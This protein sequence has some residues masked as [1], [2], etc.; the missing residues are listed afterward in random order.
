MTTYMQQITSRK[1]A[2]TF[3]FGSTFFSFYKF[4]NILTKTLI[5]L[6]PYLLL[7]V[8]FFSNFANANGFEF[9]IK[10]ATQSD[11]TVF[12]KITRAPKS[13]SFFSRTRGSGNTKIEMLEKIKANHDLEKNISVGKG[14][15]ISFYGQNQND[16]TTE[17]IKKDFNSLEQ[18]TGAE[19]FIPLVIP[20]KTSTN[21]ESLQ[22]LCLQIAHNKVLSF[23][24][25]IDSSSMSSF[26]LLEN[27]FQ[28][29]YPLGS[30]L[31]VDIRTNKLLVPPLEPSFWNNNDN[32]LSMQDTLFALVNTN[33]QTDIGAS[34]F[35]AKL[36]NSSNSSKALQIGIK[37]KLSLIRWKPG[38]NANIYQVFNDNAV[39][40]FLQNCYSQINDPDKQFQYYRL[41]FLSSYQRLDDLEIYGK[42]FFNLG[43]NTNLALAGTIPGFQLFSTNLGLLYSKDKSLSNYYSI[44][45]AVLRTRAFDFTSLLYNGFK[46]TVREKIIARTNQRQQNLQMEIL[47]EYKNLISYNPDPVRL[48]LAGLSKIDSST[49]ISIR[50][51]IPDLSPFTFKQPDTA[52]QALLTNKNDLIAGYNYK[53]KIFNSHL[54]EINSLIKQLDLV[55]NDLAKISDDDSDLKLSNSF[56]NS[57]YQPEEIEVSNSI[58]LKE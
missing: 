42:Q 39:L 5:R 28:S 29:V 13:G 26:S 46:K 43:N 40:A 22:G 52:K 41:Y 36:L 51:T 23:L 3:G 58:V 37:G 16:E 7:P 2:V 45:N 38:T 57:P 49:L 20:E 18:H 31:F 30:F 6:T 12:Y 11:L 4:V 47:G 53:A 14:D 35:F 21:F 15:T 44:Q 33:H 27:N 9:K 54:A 50:T 1:P 55:N 24:L 25:K 56:R 48:T 19:I 10:N 17:I 32:Y 34:Y 8:L